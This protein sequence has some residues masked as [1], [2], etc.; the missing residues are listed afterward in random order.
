MKICLISREYPPDMIGGLATQKYDLAHALCELD[1]EVHVISQAFCKQSEEMDEGVFLHKVGFDSSRYTVHGRVDYNIKAINKLNK[2][3]D[4]GCVDLVETSSFGA[5]SFGCSFY[6][7]VPIVIRKITGSKENLAIK[8]YA[9]I[10]ERYGLMLLSMLEYWTFIRADRLLF[11]T[12]SG[13]DSWSLGKQKADYV[14]LGIDTKRFILTASDVR[15]RFA[16]GEDPFILFVGSLELRKGLHILYESMRDVW[17]EYPNVKL[18]LLGRD[19]PHSPEYGLTFS[20]WLTKKAI[21]DNRL[22]NLIFIKKVD[23]QTLIELYSACDIFV[24]PSFA[25]SFGLVMVEAM[26][27]ERPAIG[28]KITSLSEIVEEGSTGLLFPPGNSK[29]L[30]ESIALLLSDPL[31]RKKMGQRARNRA[32]KFYDRRVMAE[33]SV[34]SY[35]K[36]LK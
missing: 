31:L 2:L 36:V 16:I 35:N 7:R 34:N 24:F 12:K 11:N 18:V 19:T 13:Y 15:Q 9:N 32:V 26:S 1:H 27:C 5:E 17:T 22:K 25:E 23:T 4:D 28:S 6:K 10:K 21:A 8:N 14:P 3:I 20:Q 30:A 33:Y 29:K